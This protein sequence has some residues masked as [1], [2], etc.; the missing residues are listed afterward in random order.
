MTHDILLSLLR[1]FTI[2]SVEE[3]ADRIF[4]PGSV[5]HASEVG[6]RGSSGKPWAVQFPSKERSFPE[7][8]GHHL[9]R[10][11]CCPPLNKEAEHLM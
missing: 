1:L 4:K 10:S 5:G 8:G 2:L 3:G 7:K 6:L 11:S 9:L